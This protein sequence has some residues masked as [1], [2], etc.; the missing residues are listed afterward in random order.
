MRTIQSNVANIHAGFVHP[1]NDTSKISVQTSV[2]NG[3]SFC[4][5]TYSCR[6]HRPTKYISPELLKPPGDNSGILNRP[7]CNEQKYQPNTSR[8]L[9]VNYYFPRWFLGRLISWRSNGVRRT[10]ICLLYARRECCNFSK[11]LLCWWLSAETWQ[12]CK[13]CSGKVWLVRLILVLSNSS[14]FYRYL[15]FLS[16][17]PINFFS[18]PFVWLEAERHFKPVRQAQKWQYLIGS[19]AIRFST[20]IQVA[21][22]FSLDSGFT[23]PT[24]G[25]LLTTESICWSTYGELRRR[26]WTIPGR[27]L[28]RQLLLRSWL[29]DEWPGLLLTEH[30]P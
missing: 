27:I 15:P 7:P 13:H 11:S 10:E 6:C 12:E 14:L 28:S 20:V 4:N 9:T 2:F 8:L 24:R 26:V 5:R 25:M 17:H 22:F 3:S 1:P 30:G 16:H 23:F 19:L 21:D 18:K 29:I